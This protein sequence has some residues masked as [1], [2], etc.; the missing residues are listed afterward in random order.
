MKLRNLL[1]ILLLAAASAVHAQQQ[2]TPVT[3]DT[4]LVTFKYDADQ[5]FL[6]FTRPKSVTQ[7]QLRPD[8]RV[9][10]L[11]AGDSANFKF[12]VSANRNH[13]LIRPKYEG[14]TT[15]LTLITNE[16]SYPIMIRSTDADVGKWHQRVTW[17][18]D[19]GL[20]A[21]FSR[22]APSPRLADPDSPLAP[23]SAPVAP[24]PALAIDRINFGYVV[25]GEA[26]FK[27][28]QV[29][30]D[31]TH[32]FIR[33]PDSLEVL[34]AL[35]ALVGGDAQI[36]NYLFRDKYLVVQGTNASVLLKLGKA[37]VRIRKDRPGRWVPRS[38]ELTGG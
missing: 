38:W 19:E 5:T 20:I 27:P 12:D 15:S 6:I 35:F 34:P 31:G 26:D 4:R 3:G 14:M 8:E 29:F 16:R 7:I 17:L 23:A 18:F 25:E 2:A 22:S 13:V 36:L 21:D 10:T 24:A 37:E 28:T 1:A 32:T 9:V 33:M 30:D 11:A